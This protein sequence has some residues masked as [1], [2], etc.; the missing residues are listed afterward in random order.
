MEGPLSV[1]QVTN[2]WESKLKKTVYLLLLKSTGWF[3]VHGPFFSNSYNIIK[4]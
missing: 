2:N 1:K 4:N 3:L